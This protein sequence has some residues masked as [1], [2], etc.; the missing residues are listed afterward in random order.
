MNFS[1][2]LGGWYLRVTQYFSHH[3]CS[4]PCD[5]TLGTGTAVKVDDLFATQVCADKGA[6]MANWH[7]VQLHACRYEHILWLKPLRSCT[8]GSRPA[9]SQSR[10]RRYW[11]FI[12]NVFVVH[13]FAQYQY[14]AYYTS[15]LGVHVIHQKDHIVVQ[16]HSGVAERMS[17]IVMLWAWPIAHWAGPIAHHFNASK[18]KVVFEWVIELASAYNAGAFRRCF[19]QMWDFFYFRFFTQSW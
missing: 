10:P 6:D 2:S 1:L 18:S 4:V 16:E 12:S 7:P 19:H 3:H 8:Q 14:V 17:I 11:Q 15:V 5:Y 9:T 13:L